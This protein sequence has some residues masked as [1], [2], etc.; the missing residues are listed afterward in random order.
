MKNI[1]LSI[2]DEVYRQAR[3]VAAQQGASVSALVRGYLASLTSR[4]AT[5]DR[6]Q[7]AE[8]ASRKRLVKLLSECEIDLSQR[9]ARDATYAHRRFR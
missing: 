1:T 2:E 6:K 9:P 5:T 7:R 8:N 4:S 3:V